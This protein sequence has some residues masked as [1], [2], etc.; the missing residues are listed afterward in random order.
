MVGNVIKLDDHTSNAQRGRFVRM[1]ILIDLKKPLISKIK[2][3]GYIQRVEYEFPPNVCFLCGCYG[4][5]KALCSFVSRQEGKK[6]R[7]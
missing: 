6:V 2:V 3:D 4:H 5:M 7:N 1:A